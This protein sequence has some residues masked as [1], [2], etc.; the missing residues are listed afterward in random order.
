MWNSEKMKNITKEKDKGCQR[1]E[2]FKVGNNEKDV[3]AIIGSN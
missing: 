2:Y 1:F 3:I